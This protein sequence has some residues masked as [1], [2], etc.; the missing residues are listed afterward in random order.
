MKLDSMDELA[1][2]LL[3]CQ[4]D[5]DEPEALVFLASA[6]EQGILNSD[7]WLRIKEWLR[8]ADEFLRTAKTEDESGAFLIDADPRNADWIRLV[9][10]QR[11]AGVRLPS[12][13]ALW[14]WWIGHN[15]APADYWL[16]L[17]HLAAEKG[18]EAFSE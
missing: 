17:G 3:Q 2:L 9:R 8:D 6:R 1:E 13:A 18:Y 12:W 4:G 16:P 11:L 7:D 10:A 15:R 5:F 14:L